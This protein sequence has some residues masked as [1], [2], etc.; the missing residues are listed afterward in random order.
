MVV[1]ALALRSGHESIVPSLA[2]RAVDKIRS[3]N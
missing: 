2:Q 3:A 1:K